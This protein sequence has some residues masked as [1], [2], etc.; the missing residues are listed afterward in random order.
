[1]NGEDKTFLLYSCH[2]GGLIAHHW[3]WQSTS[4]VWG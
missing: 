3:P 2:S 1:V 4:L